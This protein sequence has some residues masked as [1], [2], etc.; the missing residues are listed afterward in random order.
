[1][2][3]RFDIITLDNGR[4]YSA[5]EILA[6]DDIKHIIG[7]GVDEEENLN[8]KDLI[9]LKQIGNDIIRIT[10]EQELKDLDKL[11]KPYLEKEEI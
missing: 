11:L 1:M 5:V 7:I 9:I 3:E 2:L 6:I 4:R 8:Y 10:D